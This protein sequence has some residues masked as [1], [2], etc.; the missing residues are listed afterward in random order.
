MPGTSMS[1]VVTQ[2]DT[3]IAVAVSADRA[4]GEE[5]ARAVF[6]AKLEELGRTVNELN[7]MILAVEAHLAPKP[8][9]KN[10]LKLSTL[11]GLVQD[12]RD[13]LTRQDLNT[14]GVYDNFSQILEPILQDAKNICDGMWVRHRDSVF[15]DV[16]LDFEYPND[17]ILG[18]IA[19]GLSVPPRFSITKRLLNSWSTM[20]FGQVWDD[21]SGRTSSGFGAAITANQERIDEYLKAITP[22]V[23]ALAST[24]TEVAD[25]LRDASTGTATL[26]QAIK[27][28][29]A[30]WLAD[31][32][33]SESFTLRFKDSG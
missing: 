13:R 9:W 3:S 29:V 2:L 21:D 30:Q 10:G 26:A 23:D 20:S 14:V 11:R 27:P 16:P 19:P 6:L 28:Q 4:Q 22:V 8:N 25:F 7:E 1:V 17:N 12:F 31:S 24:P 18:A 33:L 32:K 5:Q 15:T